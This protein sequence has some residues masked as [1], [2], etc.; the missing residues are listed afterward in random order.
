MY[1][2][3]FI[4]ERTEQI[5]DTS[6]FHVGCA[7]F[8]QNE[9]HGGSWITGILVSAND[10]EL[11]FVIGNSDHNYIIHVDDLADPKKGYKITLLVPASNNK[12][13]YDSA[14]GDSTGYKRYMGLAGGV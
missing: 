5:I 9:L 3:D 6:K 12:T 4:K 11:T 2:E 13:M 8:I 1:S 14:H 10:Y 7:Y